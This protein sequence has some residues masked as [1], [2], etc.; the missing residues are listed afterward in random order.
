MGCNV[1]FYARAVWDRDPAVWISNSDIP[2]LV[3]E[4][5]TLAAFH[6]LTRHFAPDLLRENLGIRDAIVAPRFDRHG[7]LSVR[8]RQRRRSNYARPKVL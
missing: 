6:K 3:I 8:C 7:R 2:G 1:N 4:A 5:G